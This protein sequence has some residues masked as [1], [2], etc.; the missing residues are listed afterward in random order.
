MRKSSLT[1]GGKN[2]FGV[3]RGA[4]PARWPTSCTTSVKMAMWYRKFLHQKAR[5]RISAT[6]GSRGVGAG[7][8]NLRSS[9]RLIRTRFSQ[10]NA[11]L[12]PESMRHLAPT[13]AS[14]RLRL[15]YAVLFVIFVRFVLIV[16]VL[17][18]TGVHS[19]YTPDTQGYL[20]SA[21]SMLH[22]SFSNAVQ[23][24]EITRTPGFPALL[25]FGL[26]VGH[27]AIA[28]IGLHLLLAGACACAIYCLAKRIL[29]SETVAFC[30]V[31][32]YGV[33]PI[34]VIYSSVLLSETLF[35]TLVILF[36]FVC[37]RYF[38][39]PSSFKAAAAASLVAGATFTR[40]VMYYFS[41]VVVA[42]FLLFPRTVKISRRVCSAFIF[43]VICAVAFS[44][45]QYRNYARSEY[46]GFSAIQEVTLY[47]Y[48]AAAVEAHEQ[49]VSFA[50]MQQQLGFNN[51]V[52][53]F[54][55][56]PEQMS[57]GDGE[58]LAYM[59]RTAIHTIAAHP[60]VYLR[61]HLLGVLVELGD[62]GATDLLR[63]FGRYP[64]EG[65]LLSRVVSGEILAPI[66]A[67]VQNPLLG[68]TTLG[69]ACFSALLYVCAF[70]GSCY[71]PF[72]AT[73]FLG[74]SLVAYLLLASAGPASVG[75]YRHPIMPFVCI[76]AAQGLLVCSLKLR[77]LV[78]SLHA[79]ITPSPAW[80]LLAGSETPTAGRR[81]VEEQARPAQT[82]T[83]RRLD[84][85]AR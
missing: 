19:L 61:L 12:G 71:V 10:L 55:Q 2:R 20:E 37:V 50:A 29:S 83:P 60:L 59:R 18:S 8:T 35:T 32:L 54:S 47:F 81:E 52:I 14:G 65:G 49:R 44:G 46:G 36:V 82:S 15:T 39:E 40:P 66:R 63:M 80:P 34:S 21:R 48:S 16:A 38:D 7:T 74:A 6:D 24:P 31:V 45:W 28:T 27:V 51:P 84:E 5:Q 72:K 85:D 41:I 22:G 33:E 69:F 67:A 17:R 13:Q 78:A 25:M 4:L 11:Y 68:F 3:R 64:E 9:A 73:T 26:A 57:K 58:I 43:F 70:M 79:P 77:A 62:P 30:A 1:T 23:R 56:H 42:F 75:R 53:Y 76:L